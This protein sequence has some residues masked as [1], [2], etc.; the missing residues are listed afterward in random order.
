MPKHKKFINE[1]ICGGCGCNFLP[2][3]GYEK[4]QVSCQGCA[5]LPELPK[6]ENVA[7]QENPEI[8]QGNVKKCK[9]CG[10]FFTPI[11]SANTIC[12]V[13]SGK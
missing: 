2:A 11:S 5:E 7:K 12:K 4:V 13:C 9:K 3:K 8:K 6:E 1:K 10:E